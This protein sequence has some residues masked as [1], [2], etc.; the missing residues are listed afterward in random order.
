[1]STFIYNQRS[2]TDPKQM[3]HH[4]YYRAKCVVNDDQSCP[5]IMYSSLKSDKAS[6]VNELKMRINIKFGYLIKINN[7]EIQN[8]K[9]EPGVH[10]FN[11]NEIIIILS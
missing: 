2:V 4:Y 7:I 6:A 10:M 8:I 11:D 3:S 1:M 9:M 5:L